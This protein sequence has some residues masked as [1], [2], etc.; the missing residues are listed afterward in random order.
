MDINDDKPEKDFSEES[1]SFSDRNLED[2]LIIGDKYLKRE[3][4]PSDTDPAPDHHLTSLKRQRPSRRSPMRVAILCVGLGI[5]AL[6]VFLIMKPEK[7]EPQIIDVQ[8]KYPIVSMESEEKPPTPGTVEEKL[9]EE[10]EV[11]VAGTER[12]EPQ[13]KEKEEKKPQIAPVAEPKGSVEPE[14]ARKEVKKPQISSVGKP[15]VQP[16]P[17]VKLPK[18]QYSVNAASFRDKGGAEQLVQKLKS[19]GY[20]ASIME[21]T[22]PQKGIWYRVSAG[23]FP[24]R[25]EAQTFAKALKEKEGIKA[26]ITHVK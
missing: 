22:I 16:K 12:I 21:V 3:E 2:D 4:T 5:L 20:K 1:H 24:S 15:K 14:V 11:K 18:E 19:K 7:Q 23:R 17:D 10:K 13:V 9:K 25:E 26:F 8:K 6:V